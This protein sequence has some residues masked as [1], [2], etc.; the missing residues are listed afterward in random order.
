MYVAFSVDKMLCFMGPPSS[1][2]CLDQRRMQ[3]YWVLGVGSDDHPCPVIVRACW[4]WSSLPLAQDGVIFFL[5]QWEGVDQVWGAVQ[6]V[7]AMT[8]EWA[9]K[10]WGH[11]FMGHLV[12]SKVKGQGCMTCPSLYYSTIWGEPWTVLPAASNYGVVQT[13][14]DFQNVRETKDN[15]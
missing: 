12:L 5:Q 14:N 13:H 7:V 8:G 2:T 6:V 10:P 15:P 11:R 4:S 3:L 9:V 1:R